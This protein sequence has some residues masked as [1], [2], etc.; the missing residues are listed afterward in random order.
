M[1]TATAPASPTDAGR[2]GLAEVVS[3]TLV[4]TRRG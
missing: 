2:I 4:V 1:S 3:D